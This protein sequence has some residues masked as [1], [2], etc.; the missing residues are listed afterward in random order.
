MDTSQCIYT[1]EGNRIGRA[2]TLIFKENIFVQH[3]IL[4]QQVL[5]IDR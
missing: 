2:D 3:L 4:Q 5:I 1:G